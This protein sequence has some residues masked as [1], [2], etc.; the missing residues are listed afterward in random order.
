MK[1][2]KCIRKKCRAK[3]EKRYERGLMAVT[4][5]LHCHLE[6]RKERSKKS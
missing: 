2:K 4:C 3:F 1:T 5:S 6:L